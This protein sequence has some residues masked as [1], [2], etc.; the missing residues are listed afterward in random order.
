MSSTT[1]E[2]ID[3]FGN[4]CW[5]LSN[6]IINRSDHLRKFDHLKEKRAC[7]KI[8]LLVFWHQITGAYRVATPKSRFYKC[9]MTFL[10]YVRHGING[11]D[12]SAAINY[13]EYKMKISNKPLKEPFQPEPSAHLL[14]RCH[15]FLPQN[16]MSVWSHQFEQRVCHHAQG[17][18]SIVQP[19]L[20]R[21]RMPSV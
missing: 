12:E 13:W 17:Y 18:K 3:L 5:I 1:F 8:R 21:I 14:K 11:G 4:I 2:F 10:F 20:G 16:G 6:S 19:Q 15:L 9:N 7:E